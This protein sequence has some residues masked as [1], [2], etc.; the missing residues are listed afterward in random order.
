MQK[1][2]SKFE[3]QFHEKIPTLE[4]E[5]VKVKYEVPASIHT[6]TPD[7]NIPGTNIFFE[8]KGRFDSDARKKM[9]LVI[10]QH[11]DKEFI[12][13]FQNP[14][15]SIGGRSKTTVADWCKKNGVRYMTVEEAVKLVQSHHYTHQI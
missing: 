11:P 1:Y 7:W 14:K 13:V 15:V 10:E 2:R 4:F 9:L 8:T 12:M 5:K 6:Y 3:K